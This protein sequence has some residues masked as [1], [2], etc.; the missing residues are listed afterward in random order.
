MF[1]TIIQIE[2][3]NIVYQTCVYQNRLCIDTLNGPLCECQSG[4]TISNGP[5]GDCTSIY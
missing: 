4:Y 1:L 5:N 3:C 2:S